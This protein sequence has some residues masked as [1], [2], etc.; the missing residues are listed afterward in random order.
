MIAKAEMPKVMAQLQLTNPKATSDDA[1]AWLEQNRPNLNLWLTSGVSAVKPAGLELWKLHVLGW[2]GCM[3]AGT[4]I[5]L[6]RWG[7]K[8][9]A[10]LF[11]LQAKAKAKAEKA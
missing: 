11:A 7:A 1:W 5:G 3:G 4:V 8:R 2:L 10:E 6:V 9:D